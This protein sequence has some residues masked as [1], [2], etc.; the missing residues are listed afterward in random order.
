[1][2]WLFAYP[3]H[4]QS[5]YCEY[6]INNFVPKISIENIPNIGSDNGWAP[7]KRQA[8]IWINDG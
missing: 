1:M 6:R 2:P 5:R 4:N 8:I 3:G 7:L